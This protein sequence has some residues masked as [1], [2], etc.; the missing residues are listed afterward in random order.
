MKRKREDDKGVYS[1]NKKRKIAPMRGK[2]YEDISEIKDQKII[3]ER[4]DMYYECMN[5]EKGRKVYVKRK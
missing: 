5:Q 4:N 2:K 1:T 3:S